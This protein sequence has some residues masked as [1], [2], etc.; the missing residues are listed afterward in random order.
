MRR[1]LLRRF[2]FFMCRFRGIRVRDPRRNVNGAAAEVAAVEIDLLVKLM[3]LMVLKA[4]D[5]N[6]SMV[7]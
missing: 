4:A 1:N 5:G 2:G 6:R 3:M 7:A